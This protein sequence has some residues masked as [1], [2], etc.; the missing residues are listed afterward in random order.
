MSNLNKYGLW[1]DLLGLAFVS[2]AKQPFELVQAAGSGVI[3]LRTYV[4]VV[5]GDSYAPRVH[6]WIESQGD[7]I[8]NQTLG[9]VRAI[10][11]LSQSL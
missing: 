3:L 10:A 8:Q 5:Q 7:Q 1:G 6:R 4:L 2:K 11:F 9:G